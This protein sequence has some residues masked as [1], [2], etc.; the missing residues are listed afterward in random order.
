MIPVWLVNPTVSNPESLP[1][2]ER[3]V[4]HL[5]EQDSFGGKGK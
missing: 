3:L 5:E 4:R 2:P 1:Q